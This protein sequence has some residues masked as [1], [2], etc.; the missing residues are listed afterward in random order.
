MINKIVEH[1]NL[2][3]DSTS[4]SNMICDYIEKDLNN[5][6]LIKFTEDL[7]NCDINEQI[8]MNIF[9]STCFYKQTE[10]VIMMQNMLR[11]WFFKTHGPVV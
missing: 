10:T 7:I 8:K 5:T 1:Y 9:A 6:E 4:T 3:K 11:T 2:C